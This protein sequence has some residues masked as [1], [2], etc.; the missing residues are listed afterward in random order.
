MH[1]YTTDK[2]RFRVWAGTRNKLLNLY[3]LRQFSSYQVGGNCSCDDKVRSNYAGSTYNQQHCGKSPYIKAMLYI[4]VCMHTHLYLID[5]HAMCM[6]ECNN[7]VC[8]FLY[9]GSLVLSTIPSTSTM[10]KWES[11]VQ[12]FIGGLCNCQTFQNDTE[13]LTCCSPNFSFN[14]WCVC[15]IVFWKNTHGQSTLQV[16]QTGGWALFWVFWHLTSLVPRPCPA[17]C[18]LQYRTRG[19]PGNEASI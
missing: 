19:E 11:L 3:D 5:T 13:Q 15:T 1:L 6:C 7:S 2:A 12:N 18:H 8:F 17:V 9:L 16:C 10:K 4:H 14:L